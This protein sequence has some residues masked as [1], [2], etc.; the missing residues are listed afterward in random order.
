M[1][2]ITLLDILALD[3]LGLDILGLDILGLDILGMIQAFMV[4][5]WSTQRIL[6]CDKSGRSKFLQLKWIHLR[7]NIR[8]AENDLVLAQ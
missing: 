8:A 2:I 4:G 3:I 5:T 7:L 6:H 1:L